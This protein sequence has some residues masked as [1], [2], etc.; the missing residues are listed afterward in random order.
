MRPT[1]RAQP[2]NS[3][4]RSNPL[5][6]DALLGHLFPIRFAIEDEEG[7]LL[8]RRKHPEMVRSR[9]FPHESER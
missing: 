3:L 1:Y 8:D 4:I 7:F 2:L 5:V 9:R 6:V